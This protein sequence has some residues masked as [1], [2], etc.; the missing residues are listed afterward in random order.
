MAPD[1]QIA[2]LQHILGQRQ[3]GDAIIASHLDAY[4]FAWYWPERPVIVPTRAPTAVRF[5]V[6]YPPGGVIVARWSDA[7]S[8]D[9]A[10]GQVE[11]GT[12]RV[13]LVVAHVT[14]GQRTRWLARLTELGASAQTPVAG[15][16]LARFPAGRP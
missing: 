8:I 15:L 12:R 7:A 14:A 1:L 10:L 13:W 11:P 4:P 9:D 2:L 16:V 6:T 5:Q 3:P